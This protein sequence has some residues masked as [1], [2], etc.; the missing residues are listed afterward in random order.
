VI[1]Q[2]GR[3]LGLLTAE[4][5]RHAARILILMFF[6]MIV[7]TLGIS[8]VIPAIAVL[9]EPDLTA[10]HPAARGVLDFLGNPSRTTLIVGGMLSL[11]IAYVLRTIFLGY[12]AWRQ[13]TFAYRLQ[14]NLSARLLQ[15]YL[16]QPFV[17]HLQ[18]NSAT[19]IRNATRE[20]EF[21]T[22][23]CVINV[24]LI[25]TEGLVAVGVAVLLFV[26]EPV[27]AISVGLFMGMAAWLFNTATRGRLARWGTERQGHDALR[28]QRL[29]ESLGGVKEVTLL[30]REGEFLRRYRE[31][32]DASAL[33]AI[34]QGTVTQLPRLW[35]ELLAVC[36]LAVLVFTVLARGRDAS[37]LV[38]TLGLFAVAGFRFMPSIN[39]VLTAIQGFRYGAPTIAVLHEEFGRSVPPTSRR[40]IAPGTAFG[41]EL[42][43][44]DVSFSYPGARAAALEGIS[45]AIRAGESVGIIGSSGAGKSTL[46]DVC[47]GLLQPSSGRV[48]MDGSDIAENPAM[49]QRHVG[50]VP[51]SVYLT[52]DSLRRNIAFGLPDDQIDD[53]AVRRAIQDAQL[54]DF[55]RSL[56]AGMDTIVG[57]RGASLSG[58]Q[59]QRVGIAR[60]LYHDP[61]VLVLDEATSALDVDTEHGVM[62]AVS[63]LHGRKTLM[64]VAHRFT[65]VAGCDRIIRLEGGRVAG[66]GRA[67]VVLAEAE[68]ARRTG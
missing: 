22:L 1:S 17:F 52:D 13:S 39:R 40:E 18:R 4:E 67:D 58:G 45:L 50:Y 33:I 55:V 54:D 25:G 59:R 42:T 56:P 16:G 24:M 34:K 35:L 14:A 41:R 61:S 26:V 36:G 37:A 3:L 2:V 15:N 68:I 19:L 53:E 62:R 9:L 43:L 10:V 11:V 47:L 8:L 63:A 28:L 32:N 38:P 64:I 60:A 29:H 65:T 31:H 7:D 57:E 20:V 21:F 5:R 12:L 49:W 51:Q 66:E 23:Y 44:T 30:G 27:G 6:G 48:C 46:V